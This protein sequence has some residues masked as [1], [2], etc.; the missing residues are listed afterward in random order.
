MMKRNPA[1]TGELIKWGAI[2]GGGYWLYNQYSTGTGI[3]APAASSAPAS[4]AAS[5]SPGTTPASPPAPNASPAPTYSGPSLDAM[6]SQ[7]V[8]AVQASYGGDPA[9][10]CQGLSGLGAGVQVRGHGPAPQA[11]S[12]PLPPAKPASCSTPL[13]TPDVWNW[14]LVNRANVGVSSAPSPADAFPGA[15][16]SAPIT[17]AQYWAGVSP[18]LSKQLG[19][20]GLGF[21]G[22]SFRRSGMG[23]YV[24]RGKRRGVGDISAADLAASGLTNADVALLNAPQT[25]PNASAPLQV[26]ALA[27]QVSASGAYSVNSA[28]QLQANWIPGLS[29]GTVALGV[30]AAVLVLGMGMMGGRR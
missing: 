6:Y 14:Y 18:L 25:G 10:G 3:F 23:V 2:L 15:E 21:F 5:A 17:G 12:D 20:S 29:N 28:G 22:S 16:L 4:A 19:M 13:A 24:G 26:G 8:A 9:I 27:S 1:N 30:G 7:L 11:A